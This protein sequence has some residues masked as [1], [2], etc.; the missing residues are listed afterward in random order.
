MPYKDLEIGKI[1]S[2]ERWLSWAQRNPDAAAQRGRDWRRRNPE[3]MLIYSAKR[4][5]KEKGIE[6]TLTR[7]TCPELPELC[8]ILLI[9]IMIRPE[10]DKKKG[11]WDFSPSLDRIDPNKGYVVG[12]VRVISHKANRMKS[13][14]TIEMFERMISYMKGEL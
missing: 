12:N 9:P 13:D 4:R 1:K 7:D 2:N 11:P 10:E 6:F 14:M 5:A 3:Y 8:P